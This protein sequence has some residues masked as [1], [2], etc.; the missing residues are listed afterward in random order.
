MPHIINT[1]HFERVT[2]TSAEAPQSL[3]RNLM[4]EAFITA[5][6]HKYSERNLTLYQENSLSKPVVQ[7]E[8][9]FY[10]RAIL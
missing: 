3:L 5:F 4:E 8:P 7:N 6:G 2:H 9:R 1:L 10:F